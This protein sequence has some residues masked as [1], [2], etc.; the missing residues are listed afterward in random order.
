MVQGLRLMLLIFAAVGFASAGAAWAALRNRLLDDGQR[1]YGLAAIAVMLALFGVLCTYAAS[2]LFG[3]VAFG[4][5]VAWGS[6]LF[7]GQRLGLFTIET[8]PL[9]ASELETSEPRSR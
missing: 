6:Y 5:V 8:R 3:V 7:T 4:G 2:G 1:D 9:S